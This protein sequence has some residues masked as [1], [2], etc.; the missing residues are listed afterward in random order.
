MT[1][2]KRASDRVLHQKLIRKGLWLEQTFDL[3]SARLAHIN[4][5]YPNHGINLWD[6]QMIVL[7]VYAGGS[8]PN[9]SILYGNDG[10]NHNTTIKPSDKT[11]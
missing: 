5:P 10:Q 4:Y 1:V 9:T 11:G 6:C 7:L 3:R 8:E 2:D